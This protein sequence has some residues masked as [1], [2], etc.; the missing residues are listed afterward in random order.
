MDTK[1]LSWIALVASVAFALGAPLANINPKY[2]ALAGLV[3][4]VVG[5]LGKS[6]AEKAN[7]SVLTALGVIVAVTAAAL[8]YG[9]VATIL[10]AS[11]ISVI[12]HVGAIAAAIGK[13]I[14]G[15]QDGGDDGTVGGNVRFGN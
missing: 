3:A 10:P 4:A 9:E 7:S 14:L 15:A 1:I 13:G 5:A 8:N 12:G 2:G 11:V 6:L